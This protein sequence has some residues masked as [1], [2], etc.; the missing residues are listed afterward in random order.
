[1]MAAY[2]VY[3]KKRTKDSPLNVWKEGKLKGNG[4]FE[5]KLGKLA[6]G[7]RLVVRAEEEGVVTL[8]TAEA[9]VRRVQRK[10][11]ELFGDKIPTVDKFLA[12]RRENYLRD[13]RKTQQLHGEEE[14]ASTVDEV[15]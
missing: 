2:N 4:V 15:A 12:E 14:D 7:D 13:L 3:A 1:M 10:A 5:L 9:A 8:M 6:K 11:R